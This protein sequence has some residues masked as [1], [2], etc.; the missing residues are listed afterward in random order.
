YLDTLPLHGTL[1]GTASGSGFVDSMDL[2]VDLNFRDARVETQPVSHVSLAGHVALSGPAG[3]VFDTADLRSSDIDLRTVRL[4]APAV[5]LD[6]RLSAAGTLDGP[7]RN[8]T[9][10]GSAE[11]RDG[12]HPVSA[13]RG[14]VR[15]D[16]RDTLG[17]YSDVELDP[18]AFDGV[19]PSFP[20]LQSR[21]ILRGRVKTAG[22][23]NHLDID[24]DLRGTIGSVKALGYATI[25]PPRLGADSLRLAF[26]GLNLAE[27]R[28]TGPPTSLTGWLLANGMRDS[29]AAP[30]GSL[31]LELGHGSVREFRFDT[32]SARVAV[33]DR[34]IHLD[35][36]IAGWRAGRLVGAGTLGWGAGRDGSLRL[37]AEADSLI[38]LDTMV[39][40][41]TG[42]ERDTSRTDYPLGG[43]AA[44]EIT[45]SGS[46]DSLRA[47]IDFAARDFAWRQLRSP[48]I[49]GSL[50]W[51][52]GAR[53]LVSGS[54]T[55]DSLSDGESTFRRVRAEAQGWSDSLAWAGAV[56]PGGGARIGGGGQWWRR[57]AAQ[58]LTVDSL[59][60]G[61]SAHRWRLARSVE[62]E[63]EDSAFSLTPLLLE[64]EDGS[65]SIQVDG[66]VPRLGRGD[67][68][69]AVLGLDLKDVYAM[70]QRDTAEVAGSVALDLHIAGTGGAPTIRGTGSLIDA[71]FGEF[72][73]PFVQGV[74]DYGDRQL[75]ANLLLWKTGVEVLQVEAKLPLDL[76]L[77]RVAKRQVGGPLSVRAR[78][79]STAL[80]I[81]EAFTPSVRRV[82]GSLA[83]DAQVSGTWDDPRLS[84]FVT[85][86]DGAASVPGLG[87]RFTD[88][89][90]R[91]RLTGD[92]IA[93]DALS[94]NSGNGRLTVS[95]G[96]RLERLTRPLLN[97]QLQAD[98]FRAIDVR[99]FLTLEATGRL[100]LTGPVF[101]ATLTGRATARSGAL[102]FADLITKRI[103]DLEN[104]GDTGLIDLALVHRQ[105]LG[106]GF[107][108]RFLDSLRVSNLRIDMGESFWLRSSEA[109]IQ[110]DGTV[111]VD[112]A[113][114]DYRV[115]GTLNAVRGTYALKIGFVTRDFVVERGTVRYFGTPDLNAELDIQ[116]RHTVHTV[117]GNEDIPVIA[118]IGGTL[119][120]PR[121]S[122]ESTQRPPLSET[123]LVSY[124]MFGKPSFSLSSGTSPQGPDQL[125]AVQTAVS[126]LS[127]ALSSELQRTLIS[128][129][130]IPID[131]IEIR[132]GEVGA[133]GPTTPGGASQVA[134]LAAGWQ[135]G[136][137]WFVTLN[138]D[139]CTNLTRLY[140]N[141]EF[142]ISGEFRLKSSVEPTQSCSALR[143]GESLSLYN[144]YQIGFDLLWDREQ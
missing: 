70:L 55:A 135:I 98:Q 105:N 42:N 8:A 115:D 90:G 12:E 51:A 143:Q 19:R 17:L 11:H 5:I 79:D 14:R 35:T 96:L 132:P 128:D 119:L 31:Q 20:A 7:W 131:Y 32:V 109:N 104:P 75:E 89:N 41:L 83:M 50:R 100:T 88:L 114:Q 10:E 85:V 118:K 49:E 82:S 99:N 28:G 39:T 64:A 80:G 9:F 13:L 61:L 47:D 137:K 66:R 86:S 108:N 113:R 140:P 57:G 24:A 23:L 142:R 18:L 73:A 58:V 68:I 36:L 84:G 22:T 110:L 141:V 94:L 107:Q 112:K 33:R 139:V 127:S 43:A 63:L 59:I 38:P 117:Q 60:A 130:G 40:V 121:L 101:N 26:S 97:L 1:T 6:G 44:A 92:S 72:N 93:L 4:L 87:V 30:V 56:E 62:I 71:R 74:I 46:L 48:L 21:G 111:T 81:L 77:R 27:L 54:L 69:V 129:L 134:Q 15:L 2:D 25:L 16:T 53:P 116:A 138:A 123:E 78:A 29:A 124:L 133:G 34:L 136:R 122:L 126:Y 120:D 106:A 3:F 95:G 125:A 144:R 103:V 67:L 91:A 76:A 65:G 45:V 37:S 102:H 52:G